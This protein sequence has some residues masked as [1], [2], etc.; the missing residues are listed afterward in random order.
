[1][2]RQRQTLPA[3]RGTI[4]DRDGV[5][6][7]A[8]HEAYRVSIAPRELKDRNEAAKR[9]RAALGLSA[10]AANRA[11]QPARRWVVL[12]GRYDAGVK[13][14]LEGVRGVYFEPVL[15]RFHPH[16]G[17]ALELL[18]RVSADQRAL[19][20]VELAFDSLL[21]GR[22]GSAVVRRDA[23]GEAIPG[24]LVS[25][26][27]PVAGRDVY[28]TMDYDLQE[29]ADEALRHALAETGATGGDVVTADPRTGEILA[30]VSRRA[31]TARPW[32]AVTEPYE[33]GSTLKPFV[34]AA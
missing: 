24:A 33:P 28:R 5:P 27:Q 10:Q 34:V 19:G 1:Q 23:R 17:L 21:S 22:P 32:S 13:E 12:P 20:G 26:E 9:L 15:E 30:A 18:G 8:S 16:G 2:H 7:A 11:V 14:Q 3:P 6:L 31:G 4:Y 25:V 29:I